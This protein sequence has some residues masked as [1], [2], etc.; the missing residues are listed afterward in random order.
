MTHTNYLLNDWQTMICGLPIDKQKQSLC[1]K[2][3]YFLGFSFLFF[4]INQPSESY[5]KADLSYTFTWDQIINLINK[6]DLQVIKFKRQQSI[7]YRHGYLPLRHGYLTIK[8]QS[9]LLHQVYTEV[10]ILNK[11]EIFFKAVRD[12][13]YQIILAL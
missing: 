10:R 12:L 2:L 6:I 5:I 8:A 7:D 3:F 13:V 4:P 11:H 1:V 9:F